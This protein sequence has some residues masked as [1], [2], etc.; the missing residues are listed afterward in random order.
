[1]TRSIYLS[2][3]LFFS[4][5]ECY[6]QFSG[7]IL[8]G[9][10]AIGYSEYF[11]S[12][13]SGMHATVPERVLGNTNNS[14]EWLR[15]IEKDL[16]QNGKPAYC[17][18]AAIKSICLATDDKHVGRVG[19]QLLVTRLEQGSYN[20]Y[21]LRSLASFPE[22]F[23]IKN[24]KS[25]MLSLA[26]NKRTPNRMAML[27]LLAKLKFEPVVPVIKQALV[28][29]KS[30]MEIFDLRVALA[31]YGD[32][33]SVSWLQELVQK[34]KITGSVIDIL[35]PKLLS[36]KNPALVQWVVQGLDDPENRCESDNPNAERP[37]HCGY[38]IVE[39]LCDVVVGFPFEADESGLVSD[40]YEKTLLEAKAWFKQHPDYALK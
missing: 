36:T 14:N 21:V 17:A 25:R 4:S 28:D 15:K 39:Y 35:I 34:K 13:T 5:V 11:E 23:F 32:A 27:D 20:D 19:V 10:G 18:I 24:H 1:M 38:K 22:L 33:E 2:L 29:A 26:L 7:D 16:L 9:T 30:D 8:G 40:D 12:C 6:S 37:I 31:K 3:L